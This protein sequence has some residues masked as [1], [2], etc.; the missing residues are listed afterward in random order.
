MIGE[1]SIKNNRV[2]KRRVGRVITQIILR[3]IVVIHRVI[4]RRD[5]D[6]NSGGNRN[7]RIRVRLQWNMR[8]DIKDIMTICKENAWVCFTYHVVDMLNKI[9]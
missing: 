6:T 2:V 1:I 4:I 7:S 8:D 3:I 5:I 9:S